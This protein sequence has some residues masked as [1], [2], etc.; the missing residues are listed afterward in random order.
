MLYEIN[1]VG[2][3]MRTSESIMLYEVNVVGLRASVR[4][5]LA[6]LFVYL[7][8]YYSLLLLVHFSV[9]FYTKF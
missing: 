6:I 9:S 1:D 3:L 5:V 8:Y 4:K 2:L 7:H